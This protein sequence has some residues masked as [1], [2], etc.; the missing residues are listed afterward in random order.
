MARKSKEELE[1]E[2]KPA[3]SE[4][5]PEVK[6]S[7]EVFKKIGADKDG[8]TDKVMSMSDRLEWLGM[9]DMRQTGGMLATV[10]SLTKWAKNKDIVYDVAVVDTGYKSEKLTEFDSEEIQEFY[11]CKDMETGRELLFPKKY[12]IQKQFESAEQNE[13]VP[14]DSGRYYF[15]LEYV[16]YIKQSS[17]KH[18]HIIDINYSLAPDR[19]F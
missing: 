18:L 7:E 5:D 19:L 1:K 12:A 2:L 4:N 14:L 16:D 15:H 6:A 3:I 10:V 13:D 11:L 8:Y 9:A 17:G